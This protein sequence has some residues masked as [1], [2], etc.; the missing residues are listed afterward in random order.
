M[1]SSAKFLFYLFTASL[2]AACATGGPSV[3][4]SDPRLPMYGTGDGQP[5]S[6]LQTEQQRLSAELIARYGSRA[7]AGRRLF[8]QGQ[9]YFQIGDYG[10][11][12]R[13]F[14]QAWLLDPNDPDPYWGFAMIYDDQGKSCAAKAM[15][16]RALALNLSKPAAL[17]DAGRI[18]TYCAVSD[19]ALDEADKRR[20]FERSEELYFR[21]VSLN[22]GDARLFGSWALAHY[23]RGNY[24][25]AWKMV[26]RQRRLGGTPGADFLKLLRAKLPR[27]R[28]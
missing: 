6:A 19:A 25:D 17:A 18:Y 1:R 22:P 3:M 8:E 12:M 27:Q 15:M 13:H 24:A 9:R 23:W 7:A 16:D 10:A 14:N 2:L 21:A 26:D 5:N 4:G 20:Y 28:H 11:A